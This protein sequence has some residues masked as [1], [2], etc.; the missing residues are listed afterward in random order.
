MVKVE[1]W[2]Y[3]GE[4]PELM[5]D[6][7]CDDGEVVVR[8]ENKGVRDQL[9]EG[10]VGHINGPREIS[11]PEDGL[12]YMV[13]LVQ[14]FGR[15]SMRA[16]VVEGQEELDAERARDQDETDG[17]Q[18]EE[19]VE[20]E[21]ENAQVAEREAGPASSILS[22][23]GGEH[24][25]AG[26]RGLP[27]DEGLGEAELVEKVYPREGE[28][29]GDYIGRCVSGVMAEGKTQEQALGQ[30][31]GM[32]RQKRGGVKKALPTA[33]LIEGAR[34]ESE[35][36]ETYNALSMLVRRTGKMP[37]SS[38]FFAMIARDH[39]AETPEYYDKLRE[40]GL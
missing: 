23:G 32:W 40:A 36:V 35:H 13:K 17:E 27:V 18:E 29:K 28:A 39:L 12:P 10:L 20:V 24:K 25:A 30:C 38:V 33:G 15:G 6:V 7:V 14:E 37:A 4:E 22:S 3:A 1:I 8:V 5:G 26:D 16:E 2:S 11:Y 34:V 31:Y 9:E 21:K 19:N